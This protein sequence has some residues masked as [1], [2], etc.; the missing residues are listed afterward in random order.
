[1]NKIGNFATNQRTPG[2]QMPK[3]TLY[4]KNDTVRVF[5]RIDVVVDGGTRKYKEKKK[6]GR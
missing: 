6:R 2:P 4:T 3:T 1:M 5:G